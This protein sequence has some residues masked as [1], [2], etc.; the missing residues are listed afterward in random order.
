MDPSW[1]DYRSNG[2]FDESITPKGNPRS[3]AARAINFLRSL[4]GSELAE[5]RHAAELAVKEM[6][7]SFT[8]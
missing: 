4:S 3:A 1:K 5:R 6:G 2:F 7:I 8:V